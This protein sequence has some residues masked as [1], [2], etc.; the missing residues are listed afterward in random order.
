MPSGYLHKLKFQGG[1]VFKTSATTRSAIR[2][3]GGDG[4]KIGSVHTSSTDGRMHVKIAN[5]TADADWA[6]V[7][8]TAAD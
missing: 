3:N 5:A 8:M 2:T 7:T 4:M 1:T 6:K